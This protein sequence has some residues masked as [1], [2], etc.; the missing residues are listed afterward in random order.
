MNLAK[1][2]G[3]TIEYNPYTIVRYGT[4]EAISNTMY[5]TTKK[6]LNDYIKKYIFYEYVI[7]QTIIDNIFID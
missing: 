1:S 7:G 4:I 2:N 3:G 6:E 5:G